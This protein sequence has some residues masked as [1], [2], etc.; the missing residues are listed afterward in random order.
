MESL[1]EKITEL[2]EEQLARTMRQNIADAF[3]VCEDNFTELEETGET[4]KGL[5]GIEFATVYSKTG[6]TVDQG[7]NIEFSAMYCSSTSIFARSSNALT[8]NQSGSAMISISFGI[9]TD[10]TYPGAVKYT[11]SLKKKPSG[12]TYSTVDGVEIIA[13][14]AS[15]ALAENDVYPSCGGTFFIDEIDEGDT[16]ALT[17]E[18]YTTDGNDIAVTEINIGYPS[19]TFIMMGA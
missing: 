19:I 3:Q 15:T 10:D 12:G 4:I 17:I 18:G 13:L 11:A 14:P 7:A 6:C 1:S 8:I 5:A 9:A 2:E 16:F